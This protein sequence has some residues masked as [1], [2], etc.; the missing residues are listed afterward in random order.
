MDAVEA[1][2]RG[3][4]P[5]RR[6]AKVRRIEQLIDE[7]RFDAD[8]PPKKMGDN[9]VDQLCAGERGQI[10]R[11]PCPKR[12]FF[13]M[14]EPQKQKG[15]PLRSRPLPCRAVTFPRANQFPAQSAR[16]A[17]QQTLRFS[18]IL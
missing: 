14:S 7:I 12:R 8:G 1:P 6:D 17:A 11:S 9:H 10:V 2:K 3:S 13:E 18:R 15:G 5:S 4:L 16:R